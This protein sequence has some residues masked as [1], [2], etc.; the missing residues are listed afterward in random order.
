M[1]SYSITGS[2]TK[3]FEAIAV[4]HTDDV[5]GAA[6]GENSPWSRPFIA[7]K[8][9]S[10]LFADHPAIAADDAQTS[11]FFGSVYICDAAFRGTAEF[12]GKGNAAPEPIVLNRSREAC[13]LRERDGDRGPDQR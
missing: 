9:N 7:S 13:R 3:G 8:Q 6:A 12:I 10:A 11:P 5:A 1:L 4:S 2:G